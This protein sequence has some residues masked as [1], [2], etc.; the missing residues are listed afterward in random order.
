ML[1]H[2]ESA[3][4][5]SLRS[6]KSIWELYVK[7]EEYQRKYLDIHKRFLYKYASDKCVLDP[8]VS[9][10]LMKNGLEVNYPGTKKFAILLTHDI[11]DVYT[12]WIHLLVS[13]ARFNNV[14]RKGDIIKLIKGIINKKNSVYFNFKDIISLESKYNAKSSFYFMASDKDPVRHRYEIEHISGELDYIRDQGCEIGLH[15]G[16]YSYDNLNQIKKEKERI[17]KLLGMKL[18]GVRNHYLRFDIPDTWRL[19]N[20]AGFKYDTSF[21]YVDMIGFRNGMCH[22]FFPYDWEKNE[23]IDLTEIPLNI[24]DGSFFNYMNLNVA[25]AWDFT[26]QLIDICEKYSGVLTILWHNA[27]FSQPYMNDWARLYE[28]ILKYGFDKNAWMTSGEEIWRNFRYQEY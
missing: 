5:D 11:D 18:I 19:L 21:G 10:F 23:F 6:N 28:K 2:D 9:R 7:S 16:Y 20:K 22:P 26:K 1:N 15:T 17:E 13:M 12:P 8:K 25:Q 4:F 3:V 14:R 27:T 24:M